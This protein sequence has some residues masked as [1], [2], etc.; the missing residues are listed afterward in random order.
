MYLSSTSVLSRD[1]KALN[2]ER[3]TAS[4]YFTGL[5]SSQN[6]SGKEMSVLRVWYIKGTSLSKHPGEF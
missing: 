4:L 2:V 3:E 6:I 1:R 5:E